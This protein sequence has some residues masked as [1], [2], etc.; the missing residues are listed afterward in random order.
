MRTRTS[1]IKYSHLNL[2]FLRQGVNKI[3]IIFKLLFN[4]SLRIILKINLVHLL[5]LN[6]GRIKHLRFPEILWVSFLFN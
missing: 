2:V 1:N 6:V 4:I 5:M 3:K